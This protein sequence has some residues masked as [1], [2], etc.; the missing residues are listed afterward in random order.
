[1]FPLYFAPELI[2]QR[3]HVSCKLM[4]RELFSGG[5]PSSR[6][7]LKLWLPGKTSNRELD[8]HLCLSR[9]I[10]K[11]RLT[12]LQGCCRWRPANPAGMPG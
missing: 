9:F 11:H 7:G 5:E 2:K 10:T 12:T 3:V 6:L 4:P 1:M 8:V